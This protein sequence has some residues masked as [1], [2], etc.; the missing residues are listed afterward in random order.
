MCHMPTCEFHAKSRRG[1]HVM[2][3]HILRSH[4]VVN[5]YN[6]TT[7]SSEKNPPV[8]GLPQLSAFA[9]YFINIK[10]GKQYLSSPFGNSNLTQE[11][12]STNYVRT[13][14]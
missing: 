1:L 5:A 11:I 9:I 2:R 8:S 14:L 13:L 10:Q 6:L 12:C 7:Y 3:T 4:Y